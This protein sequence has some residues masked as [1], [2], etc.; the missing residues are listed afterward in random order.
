MGC[1]L[2]TPKRRFLARCHAAV[3]KP[4]QQPVRRMGFLKLLT[5]TAFH[6]ARVTHAG[7]ASLALVQLAVFGARDRMPRSLASVYGAAMARFLERNVVVTKPATRRVVRT[8]REEPARELAFIADGSKFV[9]E[10]TYRAYKYDSASGARENSWRFWSTAHMVHTGQLATVAGGVV[11]ARSSHCEFW[12]RQARGL[13]TPEYVPL[14]I[15]IGGIAD[16]MCVV[17]SLMAVSQAWGTHIHVFDHADATRYCG[18]CVWKL[19]RPRRF[20]PCEYP[21]RLC[22]LY[23]GNLPCVAA[24]Q[25][26]LHC[27]SIFCVA[28]GAL[29]R[30]VGCSVLHTPR[31][32]VFRVSSNELIVADVTRGVVVLALDDTDAHYVIPDTR[33][34]SSL[35]LHRDTLLVALGSRVV[36]LT[37]VQRGQ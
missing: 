10:T 21:K 20:I 6:A 32:I 23:Y 5:A 14:L 24:T 3:P 8:D 17:G 22:A 35:A 27:V 11:F 30:R 19:A 1:L 26:L 29:L 13:C 4:H 15:D 28:S 18:K 36:A 7:L 16:G 25:R 12:P 9:R 33:K 37:L 34:A 2:S 31:G